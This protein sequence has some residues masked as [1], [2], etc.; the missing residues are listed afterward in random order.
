MERI[1]T[2]THRRGFTLVELL[3]VIGIIAILIAILLPALG[4]ARRQAQ[5][6]VCL[7]YLRS[8]GQG[9]ALY[10]QENRG[11]YPFEEMRDWIGPSTGDYMIWCGQYLNTTIAPSQS[12]GSFT[13]TDSLLHRY[14]SHQEN[15]FNDPA[16]DDGVVA[17]QQDGVAAIKAALS[18]SYGTSVNLTNIS[19][20]TVANGY[21]VAV[22]SS[23]VRDPTETMLL[24]DCAFYGT[25]AGGA[26]LWRYLTITY[27]YASS[28]TAPI[29]Y[30]HGRH[31]G[32][33][34]VLWFDGHVT[35]EPVTPIPSGQNTR[36][37]I[38]TGA[39]YNRMHLG[40]LMPKNTQYSD[41]YANFY[42]WLDKNRKNLTP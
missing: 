20:M 36:P 7:S 10:A 33:G 15:I 42:F 35:T 23:A 30:F 29:P 9:F 37:G 1:L 3:I 17:D 22:N 25:T 26:L 2:T 8:W 18:P 27:P 31:L 39:D 41:P 19:A 32:A 11:F 13:N 38:A 24:A 34:N 14:L 5:R 28:G 4:R 21:T 16:L 40:H 6:T 12:W